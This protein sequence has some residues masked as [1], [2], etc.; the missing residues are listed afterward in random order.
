MNI[1]FQDLGRVISVQ[2]VHS[3]QINTLYKLIVVM[4]FAN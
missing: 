4:L 1:I 3:V 2:I